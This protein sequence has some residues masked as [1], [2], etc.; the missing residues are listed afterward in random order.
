MVDIVVSSGC[1]GSN[2]QNFVKVVND[3]EIGAEFIVPKV[4]WK[5]D[6]GFKTLFKDV[7]VRN[8]HFPFFTPYLKDYIL[9]KKI[10]LDKYLKVVD[11][12][13]R[14]EPEVLVVHPFP[15]F[16]SR[17]RDKKLL[18]WWVTKLKKRTS[19]V[20]TLENLEIK[21][22]GP[23]SVQ[24]YSIIGEEELFQFC[25]GHELGIT[26]DCSH[27]IS[28]KIQPVTFFEKYRDL[29]KNVHLSDA[30][31]NKLHL[32]IGEGDVDFKALFKSLKGYDGAVTLEI[33]TYMGNFVEENVE[34][35]VTLFRQP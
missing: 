21:Y 14:F 30:K 22:L 24:P 34:K 32:S 25:K 16:F 8:V 29:V 28:K 12:V 27:L 6:A 20:V 9:N 19:A 31:P 13:E 7:N 17:K 10:F 15:S 35:I 2:Y 23:F 33:D 1:F 26:M 4:G 11:S 3:L 5:A 18:S